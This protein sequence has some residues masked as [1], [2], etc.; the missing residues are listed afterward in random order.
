MHFF[1]VMLI[2]LPQKVAGAEQV[3][4]EFVGW[5]IHHPLNFIF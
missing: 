4:I 1:V 3:W 2:D 5:D